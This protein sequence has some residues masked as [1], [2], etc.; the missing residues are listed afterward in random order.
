MKATAA[1]RPDVYRPLVTELLGLRLDDDLGTERL[2]RALRRRF[3]VTGTTGATYRRLLTDA[4][5]DELR[6]LGR[7]LTVGETYFLRHV[8]QFR[9]FVDEVVPDRVRAHAGVAGVPRLRLL[10][11]ACSTGEEAYSLAIAMRENHPDVAADIT[12]CDLNTDSLAK[13]R[14]ARYTPWSLRAVPAQTRERWFRGQG[15]DVVLVPEITS[16]VT[17]RWANLADG[18]GSD[19]DDPADVWRPSCYDVVFCRNVIMY[20]TP[21]VM[22]R[23]LARI[24]RALAPG[25]YL[26]LGS[27]ETLRGISSEFEL[28]ESHG[29]FYYQRPVHRRPG[30]PAPLTVPGRDRDRARAAGGPGAAGWYDSIRTAADRVTRLTVLPA[31]RQ[32]VEAPQG[33]GPASP[34][35]P[36]GLESPSLD[37]VFDLLREERFGDA[38]TALD[39][40]P[41]DGAPDGVADEVVLLRAVVLMHLGRFAAAEPTCHRLL[42]A[43]IHTAGAELVLALCREAAGDLPAA[44]AH[45]RAA[46]AADPAFALPHVHL[47]R[48]RRAVDP[49]DTRAAAEHHAAA[50]RLL[51]SEAERRIVLFGGG[52]D[53]EALTAIS[54]TQAGDLP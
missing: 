36:R 42:G 29:A 7:E 23:V 6:A 1:A 38:L 28:R 53:R 54:R 10:S 8:E 19:R 30:G 35:I 21:D 11:A 9:A 12:A 31:A 15:P 44:V 41:A 48:L 25:G 26:F 34:A 27:A 32:A 33:A 22:V 43:G 5:G 20:F 46:L 17:F 40:M 24:A 13:A 3:A 14:A 16:A 2:D 37:I 18:G 45:C 4:G 50:A 39:R 51:A 49:T 52:F 47:A